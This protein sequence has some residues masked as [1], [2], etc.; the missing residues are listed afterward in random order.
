MVHLISD[1]FKKKSAAKFNKTEIFGK[2]PET[3]QPCYPYPAYYSHEVPCPYYPAP[4]PGA[5][6]P[7]AY[8]PGPYPVGYPPPGAYPFPG[9]FPPPY[10][11]P[12][13]YGNS[14]FIIFLIFIL[15]FL[16][17]RG[18]LIIHSLLKK[19]KTEGRL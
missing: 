5:Y 11:R 9:P 16:G 19:L 12:V 7:G 17:F 6:P 1:R 4:P 13:S 14:G 15:I 3:A 2:D 18:T 8:L 10:G